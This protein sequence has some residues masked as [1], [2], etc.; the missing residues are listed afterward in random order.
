MRVALTIM[1]PN[2]GRHV[3]WAIGMCFFIFDVF[4]ILISSIQNRTYLLKTG[5]KTNYH[6]NTSKKLIGGLTSPMSFRLFSPEIDA[7]Q[8]SHFN[9]STTSTL[10]NISTMPNN[11]RYTT[12][13]SDDENPL[14][15]ENT[16]PRSLRVVCTSCP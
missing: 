12:P 11:T 10:I 3:V 14:F 8:C 2:D 15:D 4:F 9:V 7:P 16:T 13:P 1:S 5:S 6:V